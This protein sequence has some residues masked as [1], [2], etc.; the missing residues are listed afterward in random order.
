MSGERRLR[1]ATERLAITRAFAKNL[2]R[3][4]TQA[5]LTPTQ[6]AERCHLP[7]AIINNTE[8][9]RTEPRLLPILTPCHALDITPNQL[10]GQL[11][12]PH[13]RRRR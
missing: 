4:R 11:P 8:T 12:A 7:P 10:I 5:G 3:L 9:G 6:L 2:T 13:E 1:A